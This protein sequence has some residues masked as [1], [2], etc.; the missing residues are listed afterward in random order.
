MMSVGA[1]ADGITTAADLKT[2]IEGLTTDD[3]IITLGA[4]ITLAEN[5]NCSHSFTLDL[6][7]YS[8]TK[9]SYSIA[10]GDGVTVTT[11]KSAAIF[12]TS[13]EGKSICYKRSGTTFYYS[14]AVP[15][16]KDGTS[17]T[18]KNYAT[19]ED[20]ITYTINGNGF[21]TTGS[22]IYLLADV[23]M[24]SDVESIIIASGFALNIKQGDYTLTSDGHKIY[25]KRDVVGCTDKEVSGLFAVKT[26]DTGCTLATLAAN[27]TYPYRYQSV[28]SKEAKVGETEY[29]TFAA[30]VAAATNGETITLLKSGITYTMSTGQTLKVKRVGCTVEGSEHS[31]NITV[32]APVNYVVA[33]SSEKVDGFWVDTYSVETASIEYTNGG[34][35]SYLSAM[36]S[37]LSNGT[38]TL[39][40][41]IT[42]SS[43]TYPLSATASNVTFDLN[44]FTFTNTAPSSSSNYCFG[45]IRENQKLTIKDESVG[46]TGKIV[47]NNC[48]FVDKSGNELDMEAAIEVTG[49]FAIATNGSSTTS[50]TININDGAQITSNTV[51]VYL[52]GVTT[53]TISGGTIIGTTGVYQKSG[54]LNITGGSIVGNGAKADFVHNGNGANSTGDALV[55]ESCGYPGGDPTVSI[56]SGTFTSTNADAIASY[57]TEGHAIVTG[58]ITAGTYSS[59]PSNHVAENYGAVKVDDVWKVGAVT[60]ADLQ[61]EG[62]TNT[63]ESYTVIEG[64][65]AVTSVSTEEG[66]TSVTIPE[67]VSG[68][69]VTSIAEN[70]FDDVENKDEIQSIDLSATHITGVEVDRNEGVFADFPEETLIYMPAGNTAAV[71]EKNVIIKDGSDNLKCADFVMTDTKSYSVPKSFTAEKATL[72]RTF[73]YGQTCTVCLPYNVDAANVKGKIYKY[74]GVSAGK[75]T[76]TEDT[77]GL[78]ANVPYIYVPDTEGTDNIEQT[79]SVTVN[80]ADANTVDGDFTFIANYTDKTFTSDEITKGVYGFAAKAADGAN[81]GDFVKCTTG[82]YIKGMRAYLAY[83]GG[84]TG[85]E[86]DGPDGAARGVELPESMEVILFDSDGY[87]TSIAT[88]ELMNSDDDA[89]RYNLKG[90]RVG[91][92]YKGIII[93]NGQKVIVK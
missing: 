37:A 16:A 67:S 35:V 75:V 18:A 33:K 48:I 31:Y 56:S 79:S 21:T 27:T 89:P 11:S 44:G 77:D 68:S 47:S 65:A 34:V 62:D 29:E 24:T 45:L 14:V 93:K 51:A 58:F 20:A 30:A 72:T 8:I 90:Q 15:V 76:M 50:G 41:D 92:N 84:S 13:V 85:D 59:D 60:A 91:K 23:T 19:I 73:T 81:V 71:G 83:T 42:V 25:L 43:T 36:P 12:T 88:L 4:K 82:A 10:L 55:I 66:A 40:K 80:I 78:D 52:P 57:A 28:Y 3:Q 38:Y 49:D 6:G 46:K 9:G 53:T 5:I 61:D 63:T 17:S 26:S 69:N 39:L 54:T 32:N 87:T 7:S 86:L 64:N 22:T 74:S 2:A 1:W 70:A